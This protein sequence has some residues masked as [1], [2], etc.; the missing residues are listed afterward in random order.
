MLET[1]SKKIYGLRLAASVLI[2]VS[3]WIAFGYGD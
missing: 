3:I 1:Q 2:A